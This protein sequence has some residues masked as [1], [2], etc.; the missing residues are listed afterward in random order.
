MNFKALYSNSEREDRFSKEQIEILEWF[1]ALSE[2]E[3]KKWEDSDCTS[4][5]F[6]D[7]K[8]NVERLIQNK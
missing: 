6:E 2:N 8:R 1:F 4:K 7:F 5:N 3:K